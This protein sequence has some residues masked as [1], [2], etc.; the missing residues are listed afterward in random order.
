M[1]YSNYLLSAVDGIN[2]L[3]SAEDGA[4]IKLLAISSRGGIDELLAISRRWVLINY[5][6][7]VVGGVLVSAVM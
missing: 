3:L 7:L 4:L 1:W 5:F 2:Y 6:V